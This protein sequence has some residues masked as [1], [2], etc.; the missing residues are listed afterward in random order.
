MSGNVEQDGL[1]LCVLLFTQFLGMT[2]EQIYVH[3]IIACP[4]LA[5]SNHSDCMAQFY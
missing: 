3:Q 1:M 2:A 5:T 4:S